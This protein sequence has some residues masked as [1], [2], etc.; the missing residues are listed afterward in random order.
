MNLPLCVRPLSASEREQLRAGLRSAD[1]FTVRRSQV[2]LA[3]GEGL[4]PSQIARNLACSRGTVRN[5]IHAFGAEGT[6]CL[7]EKSSRPRSARP[8]LDERHV[9]ALKDLLHHSPRTLGKTT[10]LWTLDLLAEAC[11]ARGWTPRRFTG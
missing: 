2:L 3:S 1:A 7:R 8:A 6:D 5:A 9:D 4:R 11:H 10:S